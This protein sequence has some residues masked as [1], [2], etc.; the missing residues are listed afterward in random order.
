MA[1]SEIE[2]VGKIALQTIEQADAEIASLIKRNA[3]LSER[4]ARSI[5]SHQKTKMQVVKLRNK[6][7]IARTMRIRLEKILLRIPVRR[8]M[9]L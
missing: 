3:I 8:V 4:I 6:V 7:R 1:F 2:P 9:G 5:N